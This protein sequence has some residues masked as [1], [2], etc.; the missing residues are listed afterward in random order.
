LYRPKWDEQHGA[1]TYAAMTIRKALAMGSDDGRPNG[2]PEGETDDVHLT[3]WGNA[4][5]L[6]RHFDDDLQ[7]VHTW[8]KWVAWNGRGWDLDHLGVVEARAKRVIADLYCWA[9]H[10]V[11]VIGEKL[12]GVQTT[13]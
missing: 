3:D 9:T 11:E 1:E 6:V 5:R 4:Q 2:Q 7:F 10:Q 8:G 13:Q 12:N